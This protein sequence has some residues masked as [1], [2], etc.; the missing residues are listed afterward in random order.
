MNTLEEFKQKTQAIIEKTRQEL[1]GIRTNR[2]TASLVENIPVEYYGEKMALKQ[3]ASISIAPPREIVIQAWDKEAVLGIVKAINSSSL[4]LNANPDGNLIKIFLPELSMERREELVRHVKKETEKYK[5]EIRKERDEA[6]K[7][8]ENAFVSKDINEDLKFKLKNDIQ[9]ET[10][11]AN[12]K[13]E[14]L[15]ESKIREITE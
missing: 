11:N 5:I 12:Q 1:Q 4:N 3:V 14:N 9:K 2:P 8:A 10:E 13:L 7:K 6:N 15:L